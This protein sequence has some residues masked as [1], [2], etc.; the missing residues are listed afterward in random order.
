MSTRTTPLETCLCSAGKAT[1]PHTRG[2]FG[3]ER[4]VSLSLEETY[5]PM[6]TEGIW[7]LQARRG[8]KWG[9]GWVGL[10]TLVLP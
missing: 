6:S 8:D 9:W 7:S 5:N 3:F 2:Y 4:S 1:I 10:R